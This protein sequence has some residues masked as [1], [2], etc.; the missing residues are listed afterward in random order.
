MKF[1]LNDLGTGKIVAIVDRWSLF[2]DKSIINNSMPNPKIMAVVKGGH[3]SLLDC[4]SKFWDSYLS[5][6]LTLLVK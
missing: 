1:N 6:V 3:Y 5:F 4:I 2:T